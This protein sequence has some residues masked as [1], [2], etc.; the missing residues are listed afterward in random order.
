MDNLEPNIRNAARA[1]I[2]RDNH[3]LLLHK[4]GDE[5]GERYA[6]PGGA[7]DPGETL[8]QALLRECYEEIGTQVEILDLIHVADFFKQRSGPPPSIRHQIEFLFSCGVPDSYE[9]QNGPRP[10]SHQLN[11]IWAR[12]D[13]LSDMKVLPESIASWLTEPHR[14]NNKVYQGLIT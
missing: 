9:P 2:I 8:Q 12:L 10:D 4:G 3:V 7:Q 13:E 11:V 1:L 14:T 5:Q 6:F